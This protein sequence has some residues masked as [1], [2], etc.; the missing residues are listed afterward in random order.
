MKVTEIDD[1]LLQ[2]R[3]LKQLTLSANVIT[4]VDSRRLPEGLEVSYYK[5]EFLGVNS[6]MG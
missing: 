6:G 3:N 1:G 4:R 2:F 5:W